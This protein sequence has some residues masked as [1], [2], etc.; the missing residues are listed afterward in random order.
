MRSPPATGGSRSSAARTLE[1]RNALLPDAPLPAARRGLPARA[2][3]A[4]PR[5]QIDAIERDQ[6]FAFAVPVLRAW[7]AFRARARAI[8]SPPCR[9]R[10]GSGVG[11]RLCRRASRRCCCSRTGR[12]EAAGRAAARRPLGRPARRAAAHRRRRPARPPRPSATRRWR[13]SRATAPSLAAAR[14][15]DRGRPAAARRDRRRRRRRRRIA[16]PALA[17]SARAGADRARARSSRGSPPGSR[18]TIA[19]PGWSPPN[20]SASRTGSGSP[21]PLLANVARRRSLRGDRARPAHPPARSPAATATAA[22]AAALDGDPS[23]GA[24]AATDWVRL[25]EVYVA[26]DRQRRGGRGL[27]PRARVAPRQRRHAGRMGARG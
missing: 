18:R 12:P 24:A 27:R 8:R 6:L 25:G 21:S 17:R 16:G 5:A 19:R 11:R 13:C 4:P 20:C 10:A 9:R 3:G 1:R 26:M 14:R 22:L 2:T 23:A 15:A 7:L